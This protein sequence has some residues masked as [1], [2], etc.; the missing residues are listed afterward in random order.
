M[1]R[2]FAA[3]SRPSFGGSGG[4]SRSFRGGDGGGSSIG[5]SSSI[6]P[7][8]SFG[9]RGGRGGGGESVSRALRSMNRGS[10]DGGGSN[11]G[12]RSSADALSRSFDHG[13]SSFRPSGRNS[14]EGSASVGRSLRESSSR[15][16]LNN[17]TLNRRLSADSANRGSSRRDNSVGRAAWA[18]A[19]ANSQARRNGGD[20]AGRR[21]A[22]SLDSSSLTQRFRGGSNDEGGGRAD[23]Q[24]RQRELRRGDLA[25]ARPTKDQVRDFLKLSDRAPR[26]LADQGDA[27]RRGRRG[28]NGDQNPAE[29]LPNNIS[30]RD[31]NFRPRGRDGNLVGRDL[32]ESGP[33][34]RDGN[35]GGDGQWRRWRGGELGKGDHRDR[36][37]K[38]R[39]GER[40]DVAHHI[41]DNWHGRHWKDRHDV[42]F[43]G[44]WWTHHRHRHHHHHHGHHWHGGWWWNTWGLN[45]SFHRPFYWWNWCPAPVLST[46][47]VYDWATPYYW[48][49]GPGEY[50]HCYNNVVYVNGQWFEPAPVYYERTVQ[51]AERAP[52]I[53][54][55]Q[56]AQIEWMP[57]GVFA[58]SREGVVDNNLLV[59]LAVT[60]DGR[61]GGTVLNQVTG[62]SF[63]VAGTVDRESQR[64][65]W[66]Y[67]DEN[68]QK[69][70]ME[71]SI[72][73]LT[74]PES[75]A[76]LHSGPEDMQVVELVRLEEPNVDGSG[77]AGAAVGASVEANAK[78]PAPAE[79][80]LPPPANGSD[81]SPVPGSTPAPE[82]APALVPPAPTNNRP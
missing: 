30:G 55:Q 6:Q 81:A 20:A 50:I 54:P 5:R 61:I 78:P 21:N 72:F 63:D 52:E 17:S 31:A 4:G 47:L 48:D 14:L 7:R 29:R 46:W 77:A 42:P 37:G 13:P 23:F 76:L 45:A 60:K 62:V 16:S 41:R 70:A 58:L 28:G 44:D 74:Q 59:Q 67:V 18:E 24:R 35:R 73:N 43:H 39:D 65:A 15:R 10:Y 56:A 69:I 11:R 38:W 36:S 9:G 33:N 32:S 80:E 49:Y 53:M 51:L 25:A 34:R 40:F 71:T 22:G 27:S 3:Q 64:A 79:A 12:S 1:S 68:G 2:S 75:T 26:R 8:P 19:L 82:S 57:L 66:T